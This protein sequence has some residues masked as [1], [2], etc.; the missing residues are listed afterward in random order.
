MKEKV[1]VIVGPTAVGKT[2]LSI[3]MAKAFNGEIISGD[4]L[5]IYRGLD[6]GT[7][8]VTE[9]EKEGIPH[10]LIDIRDLG[11]TYSVAEFQKEARELISDMSS[12][13]K[14]PIIVGGTGLYIQS[15]LFDFE[16]G[17][18]EG[19]VTN[20]VLR[21][22]LE[23]YAETY[24]NIQLWE[25]L[26]SQDEKAA[27]LIHPNNVRRVIR[28]IEIIEQT[29][30]S[31]TEQPRVDFKDLSLSRYDVKLIALETQREVLYERINKRID[32]MLNQG[33]LAEAQRVYD[34]GPSQAA[35]GIGYK[36]FF[37]YFSGEESLAESVAMAQQQ[38]RRY[39]KRQLTWFR[40][41]MTCEW[42]D[43]TTTEKLNELM[44]AVDHWLKEK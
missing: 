18:S 7:A 32:K 22:E 39:A 38:S 23:V 24:G 5:Q 35:Q 17:S 15:L 26:R 11:D 28:A 37:P 13:G 6:V 4:A 21:A 25:R 10:Y 33:L 9:S 44:V 14:L 3:E 43:I 42:W 31:M 8:K 27:E 30:T 1:C 2:K 20:Q 16:L 29:G 34:F 41:R 19:D 40:N 36:E 12:R